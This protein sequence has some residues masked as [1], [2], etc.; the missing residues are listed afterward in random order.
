MNIQRIKRHVSKKITN[1]ARGQECLVRSKLCNQ[2]SS[3]TVFAHLGGA[4]MATKHS[5][6]LGCYA[7]SDCHR[8]ID[9]DYQGYSPAAVQTMEYEAIFRTQ[10]KL[11]DDGVLKI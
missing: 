4:G 2:D 3:T 1:S 10:Q 5:D 11:L 8:L 6:I 9:G 7:C